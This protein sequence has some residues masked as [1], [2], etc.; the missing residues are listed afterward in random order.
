MKI[1]RFETGICSFI[2]ILVFAILPVTSS[3]QIS[4]N[5]DS[6]VSDIGLTDKVD[7]QKIKKTGYERDL[8]PRK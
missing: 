2:F 7:T 3:G 8:F 1:K 6:I 5:D 4:N